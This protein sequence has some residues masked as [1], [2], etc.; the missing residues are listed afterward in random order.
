MKDMVQVACLFGRRHGIGVVLAR[1]CRGAVFVT[2][3]A[4][5]DVIPHPGLLI[6]MQTK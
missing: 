3:E 4:R 5:H 6:N 1:S 2:L